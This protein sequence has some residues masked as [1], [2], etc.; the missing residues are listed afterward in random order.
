MRC[1]QPHCLMLKR[2]CEYCLSRN[3]DVC[4]IGETCSGDSFAAPEVGLHIH[5]RR[6][7]YTRTSWPPTLAGVGLWFSFC[8]FSG[9]QNYMSVWSFESDPFCVE[10]T[11][12]SPR[13]TKRAISYLFNLNKGQLLLSELALYQ[14]FWT[15]W[16]IRPSFD[17]AVCHQLGDACQ[18]FH[19]EL[20]A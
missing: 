13:F 6:K 10:A 16:C 3:S 18:A 8:K 4:E 20:N 17:W 9:L 19:L 14:L 7:R 1:L 15:K 2:F 12:R 11:R 5:H